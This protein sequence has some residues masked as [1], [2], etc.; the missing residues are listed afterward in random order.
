MLSTDNV[1]CLLDIN[2]YYEFWDV[3]LMWLVDCVTSTKF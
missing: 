3:Y 1:A 2:Y